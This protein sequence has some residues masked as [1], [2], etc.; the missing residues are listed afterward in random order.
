MFHDSILRAYDVRGI[1]G[2]T[3]FN[4]DAFAVGYGFGKCVLDA[5]GSGC[6]AVGYDGRISSPVLAHYFMSGLIAAGCKVINFGAVPTPALYY[7]VATRADVVAGVMITGS[8]NPQDH[9]GFKLTLKERPF[10]GPEIAAF[11]D[12]MRPEIELLEKTPPVY[13]VMDD[14]VQALVQNISLGALKVVWDPGNGIGGP[15]LQKLIQKIPGAH[16][17]I[18]AEVD[19]TFPNHHPDPS[20]PETLEQLRLVV[21][22]H[23][24]DIG[25]AFDGDGDRLGVV[26]NKGKIWRSEDVMMFF[27]ET[28]RPE[29]R[30]LL[31]DVKIGDSFYDQAL[32]YGAHVVRVK[33]G[34]SFIKEKIKG[35]NACFAGEYSGHF[36]FN[37]RYYGYDD[38]FYAAMRVLEILSQNPHKAAHEYYQG[39]PHYCSLKET[40]I[41]CVTADK[42]W[43]YVEDIALKLKKNGIHFDRLDG[44]RVVSDYGWWMVRA[45]NTQEIVTILGESKNEEDVLLLID[46]I[47]SLTG[48]EVIQ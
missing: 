39:L 47:L 1:Y 44:V 30:P 9:N 13:D 6:I 42:K 38:G 8:H 34:H 43:Q 15:L 2:K 48:I 18:N 36:F 14:Y 20:V 23:K 11:K 17:I 7:G 4:E 35:I 37:D 32:S 41:S 3:L 16:T 21:L 33:S 22:D 26:D 45:S 12:M 10:F 19:A 24:A 29:G 40:V 27:L 5:E 28:L 25:L 31:A 46:E